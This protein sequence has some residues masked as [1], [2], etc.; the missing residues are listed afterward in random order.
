MG[1]IKE[2]IFYKDT[3]DWE[4]II[5]SFLA[6]KIDDICH[7][8]NDEYS[9]SME[10]LHNIDDNMF[11]SFQDWKQWI[12]SIVKTLTQVHALGIVHSDI[13]LDNIMKRGIKPILIDWG[14]STFW[15]QRALCTTTMQS[16]DPAFLMNCHN[17]VFERHHPVNDLYSLGMTLYYHILRISKIVTTEDIFDEYLEYKNYDKCLETS[18]RNY[19]A[20]LW[21][22][23]HLSLY[24]V[25]TDNEFQNVWLSS[26]LPF[27]SRIKEACNILNEKNNW[28][29]LD[30]SW[31][32]NCISSMLHPNPIHRLK[33]CEQ[34]IGYKLPKYPDL[35][36]ISKK[37][38]NDIFKHFVPQL[39]DTDI[40]KFF[41]SGMLSI[42]KNELNLDSIIKA[43]QICS[44]YLDRNFLNEEIEAIC[45][46]KSTNKDLRDQPGM[47][48]HGYDPIYSTFLFIS[49]F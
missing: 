32:S 20:K 49:K 48:P 47:Y 25:S 3:H 10:M 15:G 16:L 6:T 28:S 38:Y 42:N 29:I 40:H 30:V 41:S 17:T 45:S 34:Y 33:L 37:T 44:I 21:L 8:T 13:R 26:K 27:I 2:N 1:K 46:C 43:M 9:M 39:K 36:H 4:I 12:N 22:I 14:N 7:C 11:S 24:G 23:N 18:K 31:I 5:S 19:L 35:E